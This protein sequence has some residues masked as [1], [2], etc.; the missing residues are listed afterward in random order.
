MDRIEADRDLSRC[1]ECSSRLVEPTWWET[2]GPGLWR[3]WLWCPN[4]MHAS[5]GVFSHACATRF[6]EGLDAATTL[7]I[8]AL[9]YAERT[10]MREDCE[11]FIGAL[12]VDAIL[13]DDF[14]YRAAPR[15]AAR[16]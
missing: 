1:G 2:A 15:P 9:R 16:L 14:E 10:R 13:P 5:G 11:R 8:A 12:T 3:V 4:C 7:M 6:D